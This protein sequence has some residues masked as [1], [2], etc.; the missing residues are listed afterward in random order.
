MTPSENV[1]SILK[2][3]IRPDEAGE[4]YLMT[5]WRVA[6]RIASEQLGLDRFAL[7]GV[8]G[9]LRTK[10]DRVAELAAHWHRVHRGIIPPGQLAYLGEFRIQPKPNP[11]DL[12]QAQM[13][14]SQDLEQCGRMEF[15][16]DGVDAAA[17]AE[18]MFGLPVM[19]PLEV[20]L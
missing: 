13:M 6:G 18:A 9:R 5:D 7:I 15:E 3:G 4:V 20:D 19:E 10:T 14:I 8:L 16:L 2:H 1:Q 12:L 11:F 17:I